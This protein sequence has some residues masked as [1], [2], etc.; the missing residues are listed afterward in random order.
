MP[1]IRWTSALFVV[2]A[3]VACTEV[4]RPRQ[5]KAS[6]VKVPDCAGPATSLD[7]SLAATLPPRDGSMNPDDHWADL[8][9]RTPGG[10]AG[11]MLADG[12]PTLMLTDPSKAAEAKQALAPSFP[13]FDIRGAQVREARWNFAQLVDWYNYLAQKTSVWATP[14]IT[15]GDKDEAANRIGYGVEDSTSLGNLVRKLS[16]MD[17]PC[18]LIN[19]RVTGRAILL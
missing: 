13:S 11:I 15:S 9:K 4:T 10:F 18:D 12:T 7:P 3:A 6:F 5:L 1:L 8:A 17:L 16:A 2:A 19:V 14:G